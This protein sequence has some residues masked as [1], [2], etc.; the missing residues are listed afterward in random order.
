M[1]ISLAG[2]KYDCT[3]AWQY[4]RLLE[5]HWE[6]SG[7]ESARNL[8]LCLENNCMTS[9]EVTLLKHW[10]LFECFQYPGK[11]LTD[12]LQLIFVSFSPQHGS[13][14]SPQHGSGYLSHSLKPCG[15]EAIGMA[16]CASGMACWSQDG[17][18]KDFALQIWGYVFW[19]LIVAS[20][21]QDAVH[22]GFTPLAKEATRKFKG[23]T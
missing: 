14:F 3:N 6:Y 20:D 16:T 12:K 15:Q 17:Q 8:F 22:H 9:N 18:Y 4:I 10:N 2:L 19:F 7:E 5:C 1:S 11:R 21:D 13:G 23:A